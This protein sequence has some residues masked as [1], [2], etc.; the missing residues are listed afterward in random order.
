MLRSL[1]C[2]SMS[3]ICAISMPSGSASWR[4]ASSAAAFASAW[5]T[6][7]GMSVLGV[8]YRDALSRSVSRGGGTLPRLHAGRAGRGE[9]ADRPARPRRAGRRTRAAAR[10][11]GGRPGAAGACAGN[12]ARSRSV[13]ARS[14]ARAGRGRPAARRDA[15]PARRVGAHR[16][17]AVRPR[18]ALFALADH[19]LLRETWFTPTG[20]GEALH[21][22][23][24]ARGWFLRSAVAWERAGATSPRRSRA[25][26][27][28]RRPS[29]SIAPSR[30]GAS[31]ALVPALE[32]ALA[33]SPGR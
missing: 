26:T 11:C 19:A 8:G 1:P 28:S 30:R 31:G 17:D 29:R 21:V 22:P 12:G 15:E 27:S 23:P 9:M 16:H 5:P 32:P 10:R 6:R 13:A 14:L 4:A 25:C 18:P 2:P 20:W 33:P 24:V 7:A 3:S